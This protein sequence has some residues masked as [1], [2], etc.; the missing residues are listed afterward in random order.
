MVAGRV[1]RAGD[2][3]GMMRRVRGVVVSGVR[4]RH[5]E[6]WEE[7]RE[8][9][10]RVRWEGVELGIAGRGWARAGPDG[11]IDRELT[12]AE[13]VEEETGRL[14]VSGWRDG[15]GFE[16]WAIFS[17]LLGCSGLGLNSKLRK[18]ATWR[19]LIGLL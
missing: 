5:G 18:G 17:L 8:Q 19:V 4:D 13:G 10:L 3:A 15:I 1:E 6:L 9:E 7:G 12:D 16:T 11:G 2:E 14:L